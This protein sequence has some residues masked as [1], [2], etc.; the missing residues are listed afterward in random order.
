[1]MFGIGA[2]MSAVNAAQ[3]V[4]RNLER[5]T[6]RERRRR[7]RGRGPGEA[8]VASGPALHATPRRFRRRARS[9]T[10]LWILLGAG[11]LFGLSLL[12]LGIL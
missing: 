9:W 10:A 1:M 3:R 6:Q 8:A 7:R 2:A 12:Q 11:V 4:T 5:A